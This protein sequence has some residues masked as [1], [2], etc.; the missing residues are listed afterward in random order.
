MVSVNAHLVAHSLSLF[1]SAL[2]T[3]DDDEEENKQSE[4]HLVVVKGTLFLGMV[5]KRV[6]KV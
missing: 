4:N 1:I 2:K 5:T 6:K 3:L